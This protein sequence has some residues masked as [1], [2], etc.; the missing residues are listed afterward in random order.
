MNT[1]TYLT[2]KW[3]IVLILAIYPLHFA[4]G[5]TIYVDAN[6]TGANDG[7]SWTDAYKYLQDALT[8]A[9]PNC[10]IWVAQGTYRPDEDTNHPDGND[11]RDATFR[12]KNGVAIYGGFP[13]GGGSRDP[14]TYVT[15]L[16]GDI[17]A[18]DH[19]SDNSL[20][21]VT[22][23]DTNSTAVI[24][25]FTITKGYA[26]DYGGGMYNNSGSPSVNNCTF[27]EN[28]AVFGGGMCNFDGSD[29]TITNCTFT[30][31][32]AYKAGGGMYNIDSSPILT[33]CTFTNNLLT[34]FTTRWGGGMCNV[35][36]SPTLTNCTFIDN[37]AYDW[38]YPSVGGGICN[39]DNSSSMVINCTF[40]GNSAS[41]GG[42]IIDGPDCS[43]NLI[44]CIFAGNSAFNPGGG[45]GGGISINGVGSLTNCTFTGNSAAPYGGGGILYIGDESRHITVTNCTFTG[46]SAMDSLFGGGGIL[47]IDGNITVTN[48]TLWGNTAEYGG[49]QISDNGTAPV[50]T[51]SDV[52]GGWPGTGN[53][54]A[55]PLFVDADGPDNIF[56]TADDNLRLL[57]NSPCIDKGN[58]AGVPADIADLDEDFNT[59][60]LTPLDLDL[61]PRFLDGDFNTSVIVDMGAYELCGCASDF[62]GDCDVDFFDYAILA[63]SWLEDDPLRDIAPPPDG[64][65]IVDIYD[66]DILCDNWLARYYCVD[67][68]GDGYIDQSCGGNDCNDSDPSIHPDA[69][70]VCDGKDNDCDSI[71]DNVD[72]DNDGYVAQSCGGNDCNDNDPDIHPGVTEICD[73]KDNDCDSIIDNVDM[74]NDG[75][76]DQSCGGNDCN[77][78]DPNIHPGAIELCANGKDDDCD[79]LIDCNDTDCFCSDADGDGYGATA[80]ACCQFAGIDCNDNDMNIHPS[81]TEVCNNGK[82]DDCDGLIDCNDSDCSGDPC[83]PPNWPECWNCPYQCHGDAACNI[84]GAFRV[85]TNDLAI[86][87]PA[88]PSEYGGSG[89]YNPCADFDR[90]GDVDS[91]DYAVITYWYNRVPGPDPNCEPGGTWPP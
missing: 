17:G 51:F 31:N 69:T 7:T 79:G 89:N 10:E 42:G 90:D 68:D 2:S 37:S 23:Y 38:Y 20:K 11:S 25:G 75:Y 18:P 57:P 34:G 15:T 13:T 50:V 12:L 70:E 77:D 59:M 32:R 78:N 27:S 35:G 21:V 73:G 72:M 62:D 63:N 76:I 54:D 60:E 46:N 26:N 19:N 56:G 85:S 5:Q 86:F 29:P 4:A 36:S 67:K 53:I 66:L 43:L 45:G 84:Q 8:V 52:Q 87:Q 6:A 16:S 80:S 41:R 24:D 82:D 55:D 22:G 49:P 81:A 71:I 40:I 88:Y 83:C 3:L 44:N 39:W 14:N 30:G 1:I 61:R 28:S 65:G 74:D 91:N 9:E 58:N 48:C 47:N 64:D 33:N